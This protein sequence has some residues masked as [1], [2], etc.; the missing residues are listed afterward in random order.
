MAY[1]ESKPQ[2]QRS[3]LFL[4][5]TPGSATE[6]SH[7]RLLVRSHIGSWVW[8]QTKQNYG[9][10]DTDEV[11]D[12]HTQY[13]KGSSHRADL[14]SLEFEAATSTSPS[15]S[16]TIGCQTPDL[17]TGQTPSHSHDD[18]GLDLPRSNSAPELSSSNPCGSL[19]SMDYISVATLDPFQTY[20]S[21]TFPPAF[22][23]WCTKYC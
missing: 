12:G 8:Q 9:A 6:S 14:N 16:L 18:N 15:D 1:E 7:I 13:V 19:Y 3:F 22:V 4:N 10:S 23:N 11:D 5:T 20:P 21:N 2:K 17:A